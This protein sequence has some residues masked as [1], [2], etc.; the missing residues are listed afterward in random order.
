M[1]VTGILL[2]LIAT[3]IPLGSWVGRY[4]ENAPNTIAAYSVNLVG[5]LAGIWFFAGMSFLG[6]APVYWF[7]LAFAV[8]LLMQPAWKKAGIVAV[9]AMA[10]CLTVLVLERLPA[11]K[12]VWSPYQKLEVISEGNEDYEIHGEQYWLHDDRQS[13]GAGISQE[14]G[15]SKSLPNGKFL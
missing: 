9:I 3:M 11:G 12:T 6:L 14:P 13:L 1:F 7:A 4:L 10:A 5:S 8:A 2:L 15:T